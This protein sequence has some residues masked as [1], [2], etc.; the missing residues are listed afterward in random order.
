MVGWMKTG[1]YFLLPP[2][3]MFPRR[4]LCADAANEGYPLLAGAGAYAERIVISTTKWKRARCDTFKDVPD[5]YGGGLLGGG[6]LGRGGL[7]GGSNL[8]SGSRLDNGLDDGLGDYG[9]CCDLLHNGLGD[10]GLLRWCSLGGRLRWCS[11]GGR[12]SHSPCGKQRLVKC[13]GGSQDQS[14]NGGSLHGRSVS[15]RQNA[16]SR[17][18]V[19]SDM[20]GVQRA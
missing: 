13:G 18:M 5:T 12:L 16:S 3:E 1:S 6:G 11:L 19:S 2:P 15:L 7:L 4:K 10:R 9:L 17:S 14:K 20:L 8:L